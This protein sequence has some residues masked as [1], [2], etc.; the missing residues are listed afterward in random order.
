MF[1]F[2]FSVNVCAINP[3]KNGLYV[4]TKEFLINMYMYM[5]QCNPF[6]ICSDVS[7]TYCTMTTNDNR[8]THDN[9]VI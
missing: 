4:Q 8:H 6:T 2:S 5:H 7:H 3:F 9:T 1:V